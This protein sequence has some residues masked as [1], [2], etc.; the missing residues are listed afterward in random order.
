MNVSAAVSIC[1][2]CYIYSSWMGGLDMG[3]KGGTGTAD[4]NIYHVWSVSIF[5]FHISL[6]LVML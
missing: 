1:E 6:A 2:I 3:T 5:H 4:R